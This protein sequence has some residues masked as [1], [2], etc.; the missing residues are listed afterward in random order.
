LVAAFGGSAND[1]SGRERL[2]AS[3]IDESS[4]IEFT[5]C[6]TMRTSFPRT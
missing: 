2:H 6:R 3:H 5:S 1:L 4:F